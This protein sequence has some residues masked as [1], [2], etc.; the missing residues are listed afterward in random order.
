[1]NGLTF[2]D[3]LSNVLTSIIGRVSVDP[4]LGATPDSVTITCLDNLNQPMTMTGTYTGGGTI[5]RVSNISILT[6][7]YNFYTSSD[8]SVYVPRV[9][10]LVDK[11]DNGQVMVDYLVS[12]ASIPLVSQGVVGVIPGNGVLDTK[13]YDTD[14]APLEQFQDRLWHPVYLYAQGQ[15]VQLQIY[16]SPTQMFDYD[17][18]VDGMIN[19]V[20]LQ[21]VQINAMIFYATP[22]ADGMQQ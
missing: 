15:C 20:A 18:T 22:R 19:F 17:I 1:M 21:D 14:L 6:K 5:A 2:T 3:S 4:Y 12:S 9:D 13:P 10:F 8:T 16:M 7:Q 11:T